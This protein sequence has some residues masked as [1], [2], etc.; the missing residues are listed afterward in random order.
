M[1]LGWWQKLSCVRDSCFLRDK[2]F[3]VTLIFIRNNVLSEIFRE[4]SNLKVNQS[5]GIFAS[6]NIA[7]RVAVLGVLL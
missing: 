7:S 3:L 4:K 6:V 5:N 1:V 2:C